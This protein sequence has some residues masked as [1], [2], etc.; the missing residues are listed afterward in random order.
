[1]LGFGKRCFGV[2][3][4]LAAFSFIE[5]QAITEDE[6]QMSLKDADMSKER[7]RLD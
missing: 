6:N 4:A 7:P 3:L 2:A 5:T 1:M